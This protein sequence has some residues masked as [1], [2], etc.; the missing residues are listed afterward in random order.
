[1]TTKKKFLKTKCSQQLFLTVTDIGK[2]EWK[3]GY[4]V[5]HTV[6]TPQQE[7]TNIHKPQQYANKRSCP[8]RVHNVC[9]QLYEILE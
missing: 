6:D 3:T 2:S 5:D 4:T 1:M 8:Q 9:F 7:R